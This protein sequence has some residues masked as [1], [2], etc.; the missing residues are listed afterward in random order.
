MKIKICIAAGLAALFFC[1]PS[2]SVAREQAPADIEP[3]FSS[4]QL[5]QMLA[6]IALYPDPLLA[7]IL[8]A[9]T[10]PIEVVEA[11]RW[12]K[13]NPTLTGPALDDAL[14]EKQWDVS[15]KSLTHFPR[16]LARMNDQI[17]ETSMLGNAFLGQQAD[18]M[19]TIQQLRVS[20]RAAGNLETTKEQTVISDQESI[21]IEPANPRVI[22]VPAYYP[23]RVYGTWWYPDYPPFAAWY[24]IWYPP[25]GVVTFS[26]GLWVGAAIGWCDFSWHR[27]TVNVYHHHTQ[28]FYTKDYFRRQNYRIGPNVWRHNPVHRRGV[29]YGEGRTSPRFRRPAGMSVKTR[30]PVYKSGP[31]GPAQATPIPRIS[32][33]NRPRIDSLQ[34]LQ[35]FKKHNIHRQKKF[36][37][38]QT[39]AGAA[40][41]QMRQNLPVV[42]QDSLRDKGQNTWVKNRSVPNVQNRFNRKSSNPAVKNKMNPKNFK[43]A[44]APNIPKHSNFKS[45]GFTPKKQAQ[46]RKSGYRYGTTPWQNNGF[47]RGNST[48]SRWQNGNGRSFR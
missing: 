17:G 39:P 7:Q 13:Q 6:P 32:P 31:K 41:R 14:K 9:S 25:T 34:R 16:I 21:R 20:A 26:S 30:T 11:D 48:Q 24:P 37:D 19:D 45:G 35:G 36:I 44:T 2:V 23:Y 8:M 33:F 18:V 5:A 46:P 27:R 3:G 1:L 29:V 47:T 10:Y 43:A 15:V 28:R 38:N 42:G 4:A 40:N 12:V 22:Y